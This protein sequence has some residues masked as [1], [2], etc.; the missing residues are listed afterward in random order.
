MA[1]IGSYK[2]KSKGARG[3]KMK[4][5]S[6]YGH[7][8]TSPLQKRKIVKDLDST[9]GFGDMQFGSNQPVDL[10]NDLRNTL[11]MSEAPVKKKD[12][13]Q[14]TEPATMDVDAAGGNWEEVKRTRIYD[15]EDYEYEVVTNNKTT[16]AE[17]K[18]YA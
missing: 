6:L 9:G 18:T 14:T 17:R 3:Y 8:N 12:D 5:S 10:E 1:G 16:G 4:G 7:G 11:A 2:K 13:E 15:N